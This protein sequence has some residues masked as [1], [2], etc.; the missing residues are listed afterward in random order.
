MAA[1]IKTGMALAQLR[2]RV[3]NTFCSILP[4]WTAS[5]VNT[6]GEHPACGK[7]AATAQSS[8]LPRQSA[9]GIF[10]PD[11]DAPALHIH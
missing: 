1:S 3:I 11:Q 6:K 9:T 7:I 4:A 5:P 10:E 2:C 8:A